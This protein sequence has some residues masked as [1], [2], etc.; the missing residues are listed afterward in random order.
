MTDMDAMRQAAMVSKAW[1]Y[2]EARK[3]LKRWPDGKPDGQPMIFETGYG[4]SGLPHIGTFNEVLRTTFVRQAYEELTGGAPTRLIAFS[5]DMDGLRK[6]PDNVPEQEMLAGHLGKPLTQIPD[7]FGSH[8]SFAHHNNAMLRHFLDRFGFDYEFLS[9]TDCYSTGRFDE[10]LRSVLR[11]WDG[12]MDVMLPTLREERRQTYSPVLPLSP[13]SGRVLQV[14]VEVVDAEAGIIAFNDEEG[15]VE[16]SALGGKSK[17]QWKVDWAARW[18]A[19][20]VDYEMA[21]KDLIDSVVQSSKIARV[22]GGR[23]PEGFNYEMFLDEK[24][25]KISKSKGNGLSLEEW[26]RYGSEPSLAF[27]I[28]PEPRKAKS[29]H[30]GLIPRAVDEYWQFR[31]NYAAQPTE[32]R[33]GNPVHHIH[34]GKVPAPQSL[35]LTYGLLLNLVS[36]PGIHDKETAWRFVQRYAPDTSADTHAELDELIGLA[37]NYARDFVVP[38]LKKRQPSEVEAAALKDLDA[39]LANL[40]GDADA[41]AIQHIVFEV[42]KRHAFESL[43]HWF[44]ALYETLLGSSQGPRMGSFIA[45]YGVDN[46]RKLIA[47]ALAIA[48]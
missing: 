18:V 35:P 33:L 20:G 8:E 17:L 45:L 47:E 19:L 4:P 5:D 34:N 27:Y 6:V 37:V 43:R 44:Q 39:E 1:P 21:G 22:L 14:P 29:L 10:V 26:L 46:S 28:Y 9:A 38:T 30:L 3:L 32:Q 13:S 40:P 42:G 12:V 11:N 23:P 41:E 2:E 25:E 31:G 48:A 15:R 7:P 16:Q 36:L 24:G